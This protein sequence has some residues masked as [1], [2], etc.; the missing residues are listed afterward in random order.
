MQIKVRLTSGETLLFTGTG[1]LTSVSSDECSPTFDIVLKEE[2]SAGDTSE[3]PY[4]KF[5][6]MR[7]C[8]YSIH[9]PTNHDA[10]LHF[11]DPDWATSTT[12]AQELAL[13]GTPPSLAVA[14]GAT[15]QITLTAQR[16]GQGPQTVKVMITLANGLQGGTGNG[17]E[18]Q[19][20]DP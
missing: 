4:L 2:T 19:I 9:N 14:A 15:E 5:R 11:Y 18:M 10:T 16:A 12:A 7:G 13:E 8:T 1:S 17:P 20:D 6:A 3:K